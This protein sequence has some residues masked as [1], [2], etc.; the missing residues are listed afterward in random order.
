MDKKEEYIRNIVRQRI[1]LNCRNNVDFL[2]VRI[3][4]ARYK[5]RL[6]DKDSWKNYKEDTH[7]FLTD[8]KSSFVMSRKAAIDLT[9]KTPINSKEFI[10]HTF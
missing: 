5:F 8:K 6:V 7:M 2:T 10:Q 3:I 4:L 1:T 9:R